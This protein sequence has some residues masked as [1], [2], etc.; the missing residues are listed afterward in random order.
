MDIHPV[1]QG[2]LGIRLVNVASL[3]DFSG[4]Q[5]SDEMLGLGEG[6]GNVF[7]DSCKKTLLDVFFERFYYHF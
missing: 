6:S 3:D 1:A 2:L 4:I 7:V 5:E